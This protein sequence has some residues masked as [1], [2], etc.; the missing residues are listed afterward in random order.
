MEGA[1]TGDE[2]RKHVCDPTDYLTETQHKALCD[3]KRKWAEAKVKDSENDRQSL[4]DAVKTTQRWITGGVSVILITA[5]GI[6]GYLTTNGGFAK[7]VDIH[8][9]KIAV[10][11]MRGDIKSIQ[12]RQLEH[13]RVSVMN[14]IELNRRANGGR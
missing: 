5:L 11:E 6:I 10:V 4:H 2:R 8:E 13:E 9:I 7:S 3:E 12:A 1:W 14:N